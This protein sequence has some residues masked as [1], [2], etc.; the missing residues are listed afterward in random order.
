MLD[1]KSLKFDTYNVW[2]GVWYIPTQRELYILNNNGEIIAKFCIVKRTGE[3]PMWI[4]HQIA[5]IIPIQTISDSIVKAWQSRT[6]D[7]LVD[8]SI[9]MHRRSA[10]LDN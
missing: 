1:E 9:E 10:F 3:W 7:Q 2:C 4:V 8:T 5:N 6:C